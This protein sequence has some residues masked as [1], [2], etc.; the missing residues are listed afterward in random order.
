MDFHGSVMKIKG[1]FEGPKTFTNNSQK[2]NKEK[3]VL[4]SGTIVL[5]GCKL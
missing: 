3:A 5:R 4:N 2:I 1:H